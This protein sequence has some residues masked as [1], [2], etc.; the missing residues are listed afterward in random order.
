MYLLNKNRLKASPVAQMVKNMPATQVWSLDHE[1][2]L[3]KEMA[4]H[5]SILAWRIP[6]TERPG[7]P[8]S[9]WQSD[10]QRARHSWVTSTFTLEN[11]GV[12]NKNESG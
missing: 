5:P 12:I 7:R 3:E 10:S 1:D 8:Q 9:M 6:W 4:T 2:P 11:K